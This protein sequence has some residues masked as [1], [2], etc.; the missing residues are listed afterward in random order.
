MSKP[1]IEKLEVSRIKL[2][3]G[4]E[5]NDTSPEKLKINEIIDFLNED[6]KGEVKHDK[7]LDTS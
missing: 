4:T 3:D 5:Y 1:R 7:D 2:P 6:S